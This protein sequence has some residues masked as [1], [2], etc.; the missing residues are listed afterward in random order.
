MFALL[1]SG[2]LYSV[3]FSHGVPNKLYGFEVLIGFGFGLTFV[4]TTVMIK[5]HAEERDAGK[6]GTSDSKAVRP[7]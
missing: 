5:L 2:L 4:S 6:L 7:D 3:G 1:G